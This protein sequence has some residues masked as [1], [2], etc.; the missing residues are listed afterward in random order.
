MGYERDGVT[1][2]HSGINGTGLLVWLE[3]FLRSQALAVRGRLDKGNADIAAPSNGR[4]RG[5]LSSGLHGG[6]R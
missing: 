3:A 1:D 5:M 6:S 2:Q 4:I